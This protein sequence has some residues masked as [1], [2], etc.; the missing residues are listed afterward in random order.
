MFQDIKNGKDPIIVVNEAD[1]APRKRFTLAHEFGHYALGHTENAGAFVFYR[2]VYS[3][4]KKKPA[5]EQEADCFAS[6][7]LM[8]PFLVQYVQQRFRYLRD[9]EYARMLG[10]SLTAW[11]YRLDNLQHAH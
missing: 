1:S 7:L 11:K 8:P 5:A 9:E 3:D 4:N 2:E 6:N 10:V